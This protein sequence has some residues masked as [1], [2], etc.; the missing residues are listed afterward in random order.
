MIQ[1]TQH[2][3]LKKIGV[4]LQHLGNS[5]LNYEFFQSANKIVQERRDVDII[6]FFSTPSR[7]MIPLR[8][9]TMPVCESKMFDGVLVST[10]M[11]LA[12]LALQNIN[13]EKRFYFS[14]DLDWMRDRYEY[15]DVAKLYRAY[16]QRVLVRSHYHSDA[17]VS[18]FGVTPYI[19]P[20]FDINWFL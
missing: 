20:T 6:C 1:P 15:V 19:Q 2:T 17:L 9:A 11:H 18:S 16:E 13:A 7:P 12:S 5:Q 8:F 14:Y 10:N 4:V 3:K